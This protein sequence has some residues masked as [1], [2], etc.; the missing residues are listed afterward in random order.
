MREALPADYPWLAQP[1]D[2]DS[3]ALNLG[4]TLAETSRWEATVQAAQKF[5]R[6]RFG[7]AAM[8]AEYTRLF[9]AARLGA[10]E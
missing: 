2:A 7:P 8:A 10:T 3:L 5:A 6:A 4:A 9:F 1:G